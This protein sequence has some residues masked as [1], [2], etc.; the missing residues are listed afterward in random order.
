M[1]KKLLKRFKFPVA[2]KGWGTDTYDAS[3]DLDVHVR[4]NTCMQIKLSQR[5]VRG[6]ED[7][8][9]LNVWVNGGVEGYY[10]HIN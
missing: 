7:C 9:Y 6:S 1:I 2:H 4:K 8:L 5:D 10:F 3:I